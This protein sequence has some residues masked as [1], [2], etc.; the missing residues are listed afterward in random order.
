MENAKNAISYIWLKHWVPDYWKPEGQNPYGDW[1]IECFRVR[2]FSDAEF[3][4]L[5]HDGSIHFPDGEE[6]LLDEDL[7]CD[8]NEK[9]LFEKAMKAGLWL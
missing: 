6:W 1:E 4:E 9:E 2:D 8:L 7:Y 3:Q 5:L